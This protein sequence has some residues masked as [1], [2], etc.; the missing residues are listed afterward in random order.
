MKRYYKLRDSGEIYYSGKD[1]NNST[2]LIN[3]KTGSEFFLPNTFHDRWNDYNDEF[4]EITKESAL[5]EIPEP[6]GNHSS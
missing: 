1:Q 3:M 5:K 4:V 2:N 6:Y